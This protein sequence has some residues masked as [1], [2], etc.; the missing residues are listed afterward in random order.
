MIRLFRREPPTSVRDSVTLLHAG[1]TLSIALKRVRG[2]RRYTL[3]VRAATRDVV[4]S[5]PVRGS[6]ESARA[7]AARHAA[8]ISARLRRLPD[9]VAF[10]PG[11]II[12]L[13]GMEHEIAHRSVRGVVWIE[14]A[15]DS[16]GRP[17]LCV[18]GEVQFIARRI[19]DYLKREARRDLESAARRHAGALGKQLRRI[20]VRDTTSRWGSCS[21]QGALSFSWRL[22]LAPSFVLDYLAA[23]EAAHLEH[24]NHSAAFWRLARRLAPDTD[25]A[26]AW[27]KAHGASLHRYGARPAR[28]NDK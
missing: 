15:R 17:L 12:P 10:E 16:G 28:R 5:M 20:C 24:M 23:H 11:A 8:W 21:A 2:A 27:L 1:E 7:F 22:I 3:R 14:A 9:V 18:G 13:R 25:R 26:E 4:L 19:E 6:Y